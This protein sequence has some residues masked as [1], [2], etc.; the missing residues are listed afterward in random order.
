M[1]IFRQRRTGK[2]F[3]SAKGG[4]A[5]GGGGKF[6]LFEFKKKIATGHKQSLV[7]V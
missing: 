4:S 2:F 5:S 3:F 1:T 6:S 7:I